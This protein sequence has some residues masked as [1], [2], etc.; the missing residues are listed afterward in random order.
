MGLIMASTLTAAA[1]KDASSLAIRRSAAGNQEGFSVSDNSWRQRILGLN[2]VSTVL[3][4]VN[5][6]AIMPS[7][8][9]FSLELGTRFS[10][11]LL[12]AASNISSVLACVVHAMLLS[13]RHSFVKSH[14]IDLSFF[15]LPLMLSALF[16]IVGNILYS[17]SM[18]KQSFKLALLGRF[19]FGFGSCELLNRD[20]LRVAMPNDSINGQVAVSMVFLV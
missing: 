2:T 14:I 4:I 9:M 12:L 15:R 16:S 17:Y 8:Y 1:N 18:S 11:S 10:Q 3:F 20:L 5:Y 19:L 6:Y 7:A 13:K